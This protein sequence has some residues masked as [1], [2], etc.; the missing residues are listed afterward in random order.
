MS[1]TAAEKIVTAYLDALENRDFERLR[2]FLSDTGFSYRSPVSKADNADDYTLII[3]RVG[4]IIEKIERVRN[5]VDGDDVC[6]ILRFRTT[7][8]TLKEVPV[9]QLTSVVNGKIVAIEIFFDASEYNKMF[10]LES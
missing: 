7:M 8:D 10:E 5:F 3:S 9:V 6:S 1:E 2:S 4:P